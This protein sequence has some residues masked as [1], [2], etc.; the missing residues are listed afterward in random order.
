MNTLIRAELLKLR[1]LRMFWWSVVAALAFVPLSIA[2]AMNKVGNSGGAS[3]GSVEGF[4]NVMSAASAG[5]VFVLVIGIMVVAGEFRFN[6][7]TSTFL[8]T[9]DRKRVVGAKL[10]AASLIGVGIAVASALLTL[11]IAL[12][13]LASRHVDVAP[14]TGDIAVVLLG[15]IAATAISGLVGVGVGALLPNQTLAI[16]ITLIWTLVVEGML[17]GFAPGV[18]RWLPG[19]AAG[20]MS[21]S[22][23]Y[24]HLL[25][26][27][28]AALL[29]AGYGLAFAGLGSRLLAHRDIA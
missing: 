15:A 22:G 26:I 3:L 20:A 14:H 17:V 23:I 2:L 18:G 10:A 25:P 11:A 19:G 16:T 6:T 4:R 12:P 8:I 28:A 24:S 7:I 27:W 1:T 13:W 21:G 9:P 5:G 29:F